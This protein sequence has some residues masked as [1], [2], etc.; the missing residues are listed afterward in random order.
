M[1]DLERDLRELGRELAFPPDPDL[2]AGIRARIAEPPRRRFV[3]Q[4]R[5]LAIAL[6][7]LVVAL[8]IALSVPPARSAILRVFGVGGVR[9]ELVDK[10]PERPASGA[11]VPGE[12]KS[13]AEARR[14]VDFPVRVPTVDGFDDPDSVFVSSVVPGGAVFLVYGPADRPRA[15][16][17]AFETRG[18]PF[19][20]KSVGP[21]S[22]YLPASV[23]GSLGAW[24]EGAP[25]QFYFRDRNGRIQPGTLR[26]AT[27]TLVWRRDGVTYRLE[28]ELTL[29]QAIQVAESLR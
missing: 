18:F 29:P 14:R 8:G 12:R 22:R 23:A 24:I 19:A 1:A 2:V 16:L 15:L 3:P 7:A 27:N 17:T 9:I 13:L 5:T 10:L 26:L 28:G 4:W 20:E 6:S 21:G 25:H 11:G